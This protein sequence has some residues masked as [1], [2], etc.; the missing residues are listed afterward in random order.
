LQINLKARFNN[1]NWLQ[2]SI[3]VLFFLSGGCS[4][5]Y[6]V[7]WMR[8]LTLVFGVTAVATSTILASFM[9]GLALGSHIFG[10]FVDARKRPLRLYGLLELGVGLFALLMPVI[11]SG[12]DNIY[13]FLFRQFGA[14]LPLINIIRFVL[15]FTIL[16]LPA[17]LMGGTLPIISRFVVQIWGKLGWSVGRLYFVNTLGGAAG[18]LL[19]GFGLILL[20]G[21]R[22]TTYL[23]AA[24]NILIAA[25]ALVMD[26][27]TAGKTA[28]TNAKQAAKTPEPETET[29][30]VYS[31]G[32]AR[33]ALVAFG[34]GGFCS[35]ALEVLWTRALIFI[36]DNTTHA[37]TT[38]LSAFLIGIAAGSLIMARF[39]DNIKRPFLWLGIIICGI[40]VSG[41]ISVPVFI[42]LG[43][44]IGGGGFYQPEAYWQWAAL[45]FGRSFLVML[46]PTLLM[47]MAFPLVA[48]IY[49]QSPGILG[50][51]IGNVYALN[52]LGGVAGSLAAGF[53]LIPW[54]GVYYSVAIIGGVY[55]VMG[56]VLLAAEPLI[57]LKSRLKTIALPAFAFVLAAVLVISPGRLMFSSYIEQQETRS[58]LYYDEGIGSTVKV[59]ANAFGYRYLSIDGFPV[60]STTPRHRDI[61]QALGHMPLLLSPAENPNVCVIGLGAGGSSWAVTLYDIQKL[62]VV[63]LVPSV[64]EAAKLLPE[65]NH[66]LFDQPAFNLIL[67]D[68]RNYLLVTEEKYDIIS[69]D[70]TSPK[71]SGNGSL[72]SL[73]FYQSCRQR[74][75]DEGL[76]V[77]WLPFHLLSEE[78]IGITINTFR[79]AFPH[80]SLWFSPFRNYFLLIGMMD[81][82][83]INF[84]NVEAK[85]EMPVI[86]EE[87]GPIYIRDIYDFLSCFV[88][89]EESLDEYAG[90][91]SLNTDNH[92]FLEYAPSLAYFQ[93]VDFTRDNIIRVAHLR[94]SPAPYLV[95]TGQNEAEILVR[96]AERFEQTPVERY[97]PLFFE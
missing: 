11:L 24:L 2:L 62:D 83:E 61:Q 23:A 17:T 37:F 33:L 35:L 41:I 30:Q 91:T 9:G 93:P 76:I 64:V 65:V 53:L 36:L 87:L 57:N 95:N 14:S 52:T 7:A 68:G 89:A 82:F 47:G 94:Q 59:Y 79:E 84:Q 28:D 96:L 63:E 73:E 4:L 39:T 29:R 38:M 45:R 69:V 71:G 3:L 86:R 8:L 77:Q 27:R 88:M 16:L 55:A 75:T 31:P 90:S 46:L 54:I 72:Y 25:A 6:E 67:A 19:A 12:L 70:A 13:V 92:P 21:V 18:T 43:A 81:E 40:G 60:A 15:S 20:L 51:A 42:N 50:K 74:L 48:K 58:L 44:E 49:A 66:E 78:E 22:E 1:T 56:I 85:I 34:L 10:R 97:W 26:Y 5:I 80:A 32:M